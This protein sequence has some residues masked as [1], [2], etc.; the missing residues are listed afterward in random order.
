[1]SK[2]HPDKLA[3][4][5]MPENMRSMAEVRVREVRKAYD[6]IKARREGRRA[7]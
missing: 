7:A 6:T 5:G 2:Y 1:M 4:S 3:G